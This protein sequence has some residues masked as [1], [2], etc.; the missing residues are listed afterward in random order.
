MAI[1]MGIDIGTTH[2][3][4]MAC[5]DEGRYSRESAAT[6]W[7]VR[8][9]HR[10]LHPMALADE[11]LN[12]ITK[13]L[14]LLDTSDKVR[15]I[16]ITSMGEAGLYVANGEVQTDISAWQD[17][18]QTKMAYQEFLQGGNPREVYT[19]TGITPGPKFGLFRMRQDNHQEDACWLSVADFIVW[20]LTGGECVTHASLA[21]RTMAYDWK[22][23]T[24]DVE[25]LQWSGLTLEN[26][27]QIK[28]D[29]SGVGPVINTHDDRLMGAEVVN[30]GHDHIVAAFGADLK[31]GEIL[32]STGTAEPLLVRSDIPI[33]SEETYALR[34][35]WGPGLFDDGSY[36]GLIPTPGGGAVETWA[37]RLL[38]LS[39]P[40]VEQIGINRD[41]VVR[42]DIEKW[43]DGDAVWRGLSD[44]ADAL[45]LYWAVLEAAAQSVAKRID[46]AE[47]FMRGHFSSLKVVGGVVKHEPWIA[48]RSEALKRAQILSNPADGALVGTIRAAAIADGVTMP[49]DVEWN[50]Y[51]Y[52]TQ[53]D[54][55][56]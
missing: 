26:V 6:P 10:V 16:A 17:L 38:R 2:I 39:W 22:K 47:N 9:G 1:F 20:R 3:K 11:V 29:L 27:P 8:N 33:L 12:M 34:M 32:D 51:P 41:T 35:M 24:W 4:A 49:L 25:L 23:T 48:I 44:G 31:H 19:R 30:A 40:A 43:Q 46:S 21:A 45:D 18:S 14:D 54:L 15:S 37:R 42:F 36:V 56:G 5:T 13:C 28:M 50:V 7:T 53:T 52:R 55:I